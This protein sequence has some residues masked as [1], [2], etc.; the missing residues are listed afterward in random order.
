MIKGKIHFEADIA[1]GTVTFAEV[2]FPLPGPHALEV[3]IA[4]PSPGRITGWVRLEA[5]DTSENG[6]AI[7][8]ALET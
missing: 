5:V 4:C 3:A 7:S 6:Q 8:G 2:A 1:Q